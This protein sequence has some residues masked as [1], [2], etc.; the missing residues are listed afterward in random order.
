[1]E[2]LRAVHARGVVHNDLRLDN[3]AYDEQTGKLVLLDFD[4]ALLAAPRRLK[5]RAARE[6]EELKELLML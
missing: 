2:T 6:V 4:Q 3:I 1:M 5:S